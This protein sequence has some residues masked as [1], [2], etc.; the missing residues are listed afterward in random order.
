MQS[1]YFLVVFNEMKKL[2]IGLVL[3]LFLTNI[4]I[5]LLMYYFV[6]Y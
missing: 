5:L 1:F 3:I 4:F 2:Y 6:P